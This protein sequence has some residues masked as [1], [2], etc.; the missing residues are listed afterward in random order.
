MGNLRELEE[1][2]NLVRLSK[3]APLP[4]TRCALCDADKALTDLRAG[5]F[6][7]RAVLTPECTPA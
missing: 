2:V 4:V 6:V 1:L 5:R 7:G 3:I